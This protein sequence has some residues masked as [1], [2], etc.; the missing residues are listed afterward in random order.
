MSWRRQLAKFRALFRRSR[1]VAD[2][3]EEIRSHLRMEEQEN[4]ESGMPPEEAHYAALRRFGN[5]TLAQERSREMWGWI[6]VET[7]WQD[8]RYGLRMLLKNPAFTV[9]AVLTLA[10]GIG[11]NTAIFSVVNTVLIRPLPYKDPGRLV[12]VWSAERARGINQSTVSI[13]DYLDWKKQ[14]QVFEGMAAVSRATFNL[15]GGDEPAQVTGL[16]TSPDYFDVLGA[17]PELGRPFAPEEEQW[18]KHR[19]VVLSHALWEGSFG[20]DRKVLGKVVTLNA[21]SFSIIGVMPASFSTP[22]PRDQ[23]WVPMAPPPGIQITRDQRFM[24]VIARLKPGV[25]FER[26]SADIQTIANR[27][28]LEYREDKGV[29]AYLVSAEE[30]VAG[31][32][33]TALLI[34]LG[35]AGFV[36]LVACTNL[37]NLLLARVVGREKEMAIRSGLGATRAR[38]ARQLLTESMVLAFLGGA[39]GLLLAAW[40][41]DL[42]RKAGSAE[43]PM[44]QGISIDLNVLAFT[45]GVSILIGL[46]FGQIPAFSFSRPPLVASL[47]EGGRGSTTGMRT[48]RGSGFLVVA[49]VA[50]ALML[51]VGAG[52]LINSLYRL[53]AARL[54]FNPDGVL[55]AEVALPDAKYR[56]PQQRTLFFQHLLERVRA[57]PGVKASGATLTLPLGGGGRY[58]TDLEIPGRPKAETRESIPIVAFFQ[59]TPGYFRAMAIPV[60]GRAFD[61]HDNQDG[62]KVAVISETL[63]R[64]FFPG[65]D[66]IGKRIRVNSVD[67]AVVGVSGDIVIDSAKDPGIPEVFVPHAQGVSGASGYMVLTVRTDTDPLLLAA[68][69]RDQVRSL[70]RDQAVANLETLTQVVGESLAQ[71]RLYSLLFGAF[72]G[73]AVLLAALGIYGVIFYFVSERTHE[74]GVRMALG[75]SPADVLWLV[76]GRG[77]TLGLGGIALGLAASFVLTRTMSSM[78][79]GVHPTDPLTFVAVSIL[80][81]GVAGIACYIPARRATQVD[82]MVALRYE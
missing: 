20:G 5:V 69:L 37:A 46:A 11:A 71:P 42:F 47:K 26:A 25:S 60:T 16:M 53:R 40:G 75:A 38:L 15:S 27:L 18:G 62:P 79:Y 43:I 80:L 58:W 24:K 14:N 64:R 76:V 34:L 12:Y 68:G 2:L 36:L 3:E 7:L 31:N 32:F 63:S 41:M 50:L 17:K 33:R 56:E 70:D 54:G 22:N 72:A 8:L 52:L 6:S 10:L 65:D 67:L 48:R 19:V 13:P 55:T 21:D 4:L 30:E 29:S 59:V 45:L 9:V 73:L 39:L 78:L 82:L 66:P 23:F 51:S 74:I 81:T 57:M 44:A 49:E 1:R 61:D 28:A 35:A 77:L